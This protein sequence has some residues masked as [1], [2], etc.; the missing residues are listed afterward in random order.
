MQQTLHHAV[1]VDAAD[2]VDLR[3]RDRLLV[4]DDRQ[5]FQ[6]GAAEVSCRF[7]AEETLDQFGELRGGGQLDS[8]PRV[9]AGAGRG[10]RERR[11][12]R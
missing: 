12:V 4:G 8:A 6:R 10:S 3:A 9:A 7:Q 2:R 5:C 11:P 1:A